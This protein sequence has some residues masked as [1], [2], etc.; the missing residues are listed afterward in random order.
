MANERATGGVS[1]PGK[2][3]Q[4]Q[5]QGAKESE[6]QARSEGASSQQQPG[7]RERTGGLSRRGYGPGTLASREF[8]ASPFSFMRRM[9]DDLDRMFEEFGFGTAGTPSRWGELQQSFAGEGIWA[10]SVDVFEREGNLVVRADLPGLGK[11]DVR[12][13]VVEGALVLEGERRQEREVERSGMYRAERTYGTFRRV[14]PLPEGVDPES[15]EARFDN[16]VLEVTLRLPEEKARR[17]RIE[18]QAGKPGS[19]H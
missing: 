12:V 13:E 2:K 8:L 5:Q 1:E 7:A 16:G 4:A 17:R 9:M 10:P 14:I 3:G 19:V 6:Q 15:A 11:D 18:I